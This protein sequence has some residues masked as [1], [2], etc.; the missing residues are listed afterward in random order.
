MLRSKTAGLVACGAAMCVALTLA[1]CG[2]GGSSASTGGGGA[3]SALPAPVGGLDFVNGAFTFQFQ[4]QALELTFTTSPSVSG[5]D[6]STFGGYYS[7]TVVGNATP[8]PAL[9]DVFLGVGSSALGIQ[10]HA[11]ANQT[12]ARQAFAIYRNTAGANQLASYI[13]GTK[14]GFPGV[15][16]MDPVVPAN[17]PFGLTSNAGLA[18]PLP[19]TPTPAPFDYVF[20]LTG[21]PAFVVAGAPY[22]TP[23]NNPN[24]FNLPVT[25][26]PIIAP[27]P[28][29]AVGS[30]TGP[31]PVPPQVLDVVP[32][33]VT[34]VGP[35]VVYSEV[36][37]TVGDPLPADGAIK[38]VFS[39]KIARSSV[40]ALLNLRVRNLSILQGGVPTLVPG[41]FDRIDPVSNAIQTV[42]TAALLY[43]PTGGSFGPGSP[44]GVTGFNIEVRV[45]LLGDSANNIK[46]TPQGS[47]GTQL[48]LTNVLTESF[49]TAPCTVG[50]PG[51][52]LAVAS[53]TEGFSDTTKL[54]ASFAGTWGQARWNASTLPGFLA[55]RN[56]FGSPTGNNSVALGSRVQFAVDPT[57]LGTNPAGLFSPFD[58]SLA[59]TTACGANCGATGCNLGAGVNAGGGSHIMHLFE[60]VD[61]GSTKD[62]I[63]QMEWSPV[64]QVTT[65]T[66]YPNMSIWCG[67]TNLQAPFSGTIP[68]P[69][70]NPG[71]F[72]AYGAN[73]LVQPFQSNDPTVFQVIP[74]IQGGNGTLGKI[75]VFGPAN[76]TL[77]SLFAQFAGYPLFNPPFDFANTTGGSG[78][79]NNLVVE[80]NIEPGTQCPNFHRYRATAATPVRRLIGPPLSLV[81]PLST[82]IASFG[83]FDIYRSR[84]TFVG[85]RSSVRSQWYDTGSNAPTYLN[86][87]LD[88]SPVPNPTGGTDTLLQP[89]GTQTLWFLDGK[90][91]TAT[92]VPSTVPTVG[93]LPVF[94]SAGAFQASALTSLT[95]Q[96]CRFFRFRV[97]IL[98]NVSTNGVPA[99]NNMIMVYNL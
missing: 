74:A 83:G 39:K 2:G 73:F 62:A 86:M 92:P 14:V 10:Y 51:C 96:A 48:E 15:L 28:G 63:E 72:S 68:A 1:G 37:G 36:A 43:T 75:A 99:F 6:P 77:P 16:V 31:D 4:D 53:V 85:R 17:N 44:A 50:S 98:G 23:A 21:Q 34:S 32:M 45:G 84:F 49:T 5:I 89:A 69:P 27:R 70:N 33:A 18:G 24:P 59:S 97:E 80:M 29:F 94:D 87:L 11:F 20:V 79:G 9:A 25:F 76:F 13:L 65:T 64:G 88:P 61:L 46:G 47:S 55:G 67:L 91:G 22:P 58:A 71:L 60:A 35:P 41:T 93:N 7:S 26:D 52:T 19:A 3:G 54:D 82:A 30:G 42:D 66:T 57:P 38:I 40:N 56:L 81:P 12:L 78:V 8:T 90:N 95:S